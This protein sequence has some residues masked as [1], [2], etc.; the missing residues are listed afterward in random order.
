[1]FL[2]IDLDCFFVSASRT[3]NPDLNGK[4]VAVAGENKTDIFGD[5]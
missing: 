1:M 2:H 3:V 5:L 4:V